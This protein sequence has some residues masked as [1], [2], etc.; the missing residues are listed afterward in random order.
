[1]SR[2]DL[3]FTR[4][5]IVVVAVLSVLGTV[6]LGGGT[7]MVA[8]YRMRDEITLAATQAATTAAVAAAQGAI[9][10]VREKVIGHEREDDA[11]VDDIKRRLGR[12]E[13]RLDRLPMDA[14]PG[15]R[16]RSRVVINQEP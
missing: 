9:Y 4:R 8:V 3:V 15:D 7:A 12:L 14:L 13:D 1:V 10:P 2:E 16:R 11:R 6:A 5:A